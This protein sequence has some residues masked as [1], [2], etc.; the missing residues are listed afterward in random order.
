MDTLDLFRTGNTEREALGPQS[1]VL[2]GFALPWVNALLPAIEA[3][4]HVAPFRHMLTPGGRTINIALTNCGALGWTSDQRGYRYTELDPVSS[5]PWPSMPTPFLQLAHQ[6]ATAAGFP[7]FI[8]DACLIN[9]YLPGTRLTL[10]QDRNER[11]FSAPIVSVSLGMSAIFLF[12]G[13]ERSDRALRMPL[14]H[15]DVAVW[16]GQDRLRFHGVAPLR[17]I[18]HPLLGEQRINLTFRRAGGMP[19]QPASIR[20]PAEP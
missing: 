6:A 2:R 19:I 9:R 14:V 16:G 7:G 12:G 3:I 1:W 10:H 15:G 8:P 4:T 20:K 11:D 17:G 5:Q 18:P 13:K